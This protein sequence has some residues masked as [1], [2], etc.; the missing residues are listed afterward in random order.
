MEKQGGIYVRYSPG[1]D[2]DHNPDSLN[3]I[4]R[5]PW[6]IESQ[7][8]SERHVEDRQTRFL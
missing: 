2:R 3:Q 4:I 7:Q 8:K 5:L 6:T 1:R